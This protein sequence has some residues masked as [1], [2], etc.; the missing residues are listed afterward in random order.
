MEVLKVK[1]T[2]RLLV[3]DSE[4]YAW[5]NPSGK[6]MHLTDAQEWKY[7]KN[8]PFMEKVSPP[9]NLDLQVMAEAE[10]VTA[11]IIN[12]RNNDKATLADQFPQLAALMTK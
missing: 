10:I 5:F 3:S 11:E 9:V 4:K 8:Q 6:F 1:K 7:L 12:S 2:G